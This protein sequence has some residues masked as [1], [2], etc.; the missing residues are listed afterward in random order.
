MSPKLRQINKYT[1][2]LSHAPLFKRYGVELSVLI[3]GVVCSAILGYSVY[4]WTESQNRNDL[5]L[6]SLE[7]N[8]LLQK[9][10]DNHLEVV[11]SIAALYTGHT[12]VGHREFSRFT[13]I[14]LDRH[15]GIYTLAWVPRISLEKKRS[16]EGAFG[17]GSVK[18]ILIRKYPS[19]DGAG[20]RLDTD[21][22]PVHFAEPYQDNAPIIGIDLATSRAYFQALALARDT[23]EMKASGRIT[24]LQAL[25]VTS[26]FA[27]YHPVYTSDIEPDALVARRDMLRGMALGVLDIKN[28]VDGVMNVYGGQLKVFLIDESANENK[29]LY[30]SDDIDANVLP[31]DSSEHSWISVPG[32]QWS[33]YILASPRWQQSSS[34]KAWLISLFSLFLTMLL[35]GYLYTNKR[36]TIHVETLMLESIATESFLGSVFYAMPDLFFRMTIDGKILDCHVQ[37][38]S[39]LYMSRSF[40]V[41]SKIQDV[42]P[43]RAEGVFLGKIKEAQTSDGLVTFEYEMSAGTEAQYYESR[44]VVLENKKEIIMIVRDISKRKES[45]DQIKKISR[46]YE[47]ISQ[48]NLA[49]LKE[50]DKQGLFQKVCDISVTYGR[51]RMAWVGLVD[52]D[53]RSVKP[54]AVSGE[55]TDYLRALNIFIDDPEKGKGPTARSVKEGSW[56]VFNDLENNTDFEP[57]RKDA[58]DKG[59]RSSGSF[60][61]YLN[62]RVVGNLNVYAIEPWFFDE[63]EIHLMQ[64]MVDNISFALE[65]MSQVIHKKKAEDALQKKTAHL[66]ALI[67]AQSDLI[68]MKDAEGVYLSCNPTFER[69]FGA[70]ESEIIG[71]TDYDFVDKGLADFFREKDKNAMAAGGPSINEE[72]IFFA[73][74]GHKALLET[75]KVPMYDVNNNIIGVLG[76]GRDITER[77]QHERYIALQASRAEALLELPLAAETLDEKGFMQRGL[78]LAEDITGSSISFLHFINDDEKSIELIT[79]S[80]KT[81]SDYCTA[82]HETHY[83]VNE[84]GIWADAL[85]QRKPVVFNDY[86]AIPNKHG[87]PEGHSV[88]TRLISLPVIENGNVVMLLGV[89]N[90]DCDYT[91]LDVETVQLLANEIW[92]TVQ[93]QRSEM[94]LKKLAQAVEQSPES[95]VITNVNAEIEYVNDA[96]L[97]N[98]GYEKS[99]VLGENP[100]MLQSGKTHSSEYEAMWE[101]LND[102][103]PWKGEFYNKRK[104]GSEYIEFVHI[105]PIIQSNG[106]TS[107]YIAIKEDIT[108]KKNLGLELDKYRHDLEALVAERTQ[109]LEDARNDAQVASRAKSTFLANMSHEIRTPMN[110]IIGLTHLLQ[111]SNLTDDQSRKLMK[112]DG[113]ANHLLSVIND[114]L[115]LSKIEAGKLTLFSATF[116]SE[117]VLERVESLLKEQAIEKGITLDVEKGDL[118]EWLLGDQI[119]LQQAL[120]N[121]VGN[122][123]KF[124]DEGGVV[125]RANVQEIN[126]D[127]IVVRFEVE[128]TGI[129]IASDKFSILFNAF[130]Q[131]D[132]SRTRRYEGTGLGLAITSRLAKIM[133]GDV[134]ATSTLGKGSTFWFTAKL[135]KG[136]PVAYEGVMTKQGD[137]EFILHRHH[138]GLRIL[139]VEDN[140]IN[141]EV[142]AELLIS[143]G[144]NVETAENGKVAL[145]MVSNLFYDLILMDIKMPEMDGLEATRLIRLLPGGADIPILAMTA[146][147]FDEDR[148]ECQRVGMNDFVAKPVDPEKLFS[149]LIKWLPE[150]AMLESDDEVNENIPSRVL[151]DHEELIQQKLIEMD[152]LL[153]TVGLRNMRGDVNGYLRLLKQFFSIHGNDIEIMGVHLENDTYSKAADLAHALKGSSGTLGMMSLHDISKKLEN[154]INNVM[155]DTVNDRKQE[156]H[157]QLMD[158]LLLAGKNEIDLVREN[159]QPLFSNDDAD[160]T[161][162]GAFDVDAVL[163]QLYAMLIIDDT[164][165]NRLFLDVEMKL[166]HVFGMAA[167]QLGQNM[168]AF[169][170]PEA[171]EV[172]QSM[173]N[174]QGHTDNRKH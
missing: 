57:W 86:G 171:I 123:I 118:P 84:A 45:Q 22:Y 77:K 56:V 59:Y 24:L 154:A 40:L 19:E 53:N 122:A 106:E 107:H 21:F 169:D 104:D 26:A 87:L 138:S 13:Q 46:L 170:Y 114:I 158:S 174:S 54:I 82:M 89:G 102:N 100:R 67:D 74:D 29:L 6:L 149:T 43:L 37:K 68:W 63:E 128:D 108:E 115:D 111:R 91:D 155:N 33:L 140:A 135:A 93:R 132:D 51:F 76:V 35:T 161:D 36:R 159:L 133:G 88:L 65:K 105:A 32:R 60:P 127:D 92:R 144:L 163:D 14:A 69:F 83:P 152:C 162:E 20:F 16:F 7:K 151:S 134:G 15:P 30:A 101:A 153:A 50:R 49:T 172:L 90:K 121:Y 112:V 139:L 27:I 79:W 25:T 52:D 129:G 142:A 4:N 148:H 61:M 147:V 39:A 58:L 113:A 47:T 165:A 124:T 66:R 103:K 12:D 17:E 1:D 168:E 117:S 94:Q 34:L 5:S 9:E 173:R 38:T 18:P 150:S 141:R 119:R 23:G 157:R 28:I 97:N 42:F 41:G 70:K 85:R 2:I 99:E 137:S 131:G 98:T 164:R 125:V 136:D 109:A 73:D 126:G 10:L 48:V 96:F 95:V 110:A 31:F 166:R 160:N 116:K 8:A 3:I 62:N 120:L 78:V 156:S 75:I 143:V 72:E 130:E 146:N 81:L 44:M 71:K 55:G 145:D 64:D 80:R 167:E 11:A